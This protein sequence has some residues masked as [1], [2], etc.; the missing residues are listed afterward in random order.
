[1]TRTDKLQHL[2]ITHLKEHGKVELVL[3][4]G[5][6]LEI[7]ITQENGRGEIEIDDD[8]DYC[9]VTAKRH[10]KSILID[11]FNLALQFED[12]PSTIIFEDNITDDVGMP[13]RTLEVV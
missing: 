13:V 1:M 11:S 3:P 10:D 9:F 12:C 8:G 7:G 6:M 4:D 5:I 2:L